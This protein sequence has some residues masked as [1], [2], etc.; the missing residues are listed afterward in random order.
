[1]P[2]ETIVGI[3]VDLVGIERFQRLGMRTEGL[4]ERLFRVSEL[5][6]APIRP[7]TPWARLAAAFALKEAALKA[8]GVPRGF[9][10]HDLVVDADG[11]LELY[12]P[13]REAAEDLGI[14]DWQVTSTR[15]GGHAIATA[16]ALG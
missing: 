1:M 9:T 14:R 5:P 8:M 3:G 4:L 2:D 15:R 16:I 6:T 7:E 12:G 10:W 13:T 11:A